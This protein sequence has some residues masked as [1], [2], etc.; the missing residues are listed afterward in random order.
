MLNGIRV[1]DLTRLYPGPYSTLFLSDYGAEVIKIEDKQVG[2]YLRDMSSDIQDMN[3]RFVALNRGKKSVSLNLKEK[4]DYNFF[5]ELIKTADILVESFRPGVMERLK[6]DYKTL[7]KINK[8]LIFCSITGFGQTGPYA[9]KAGHDLNYTSLSGLAKYQSDF[10]G[11]PIVPG[12]QIS[13]LAGGSMMAIS[14]ILLALYHRERTGKG[15][16]ID[17]SMLDGTLSLMISLFPDYFSGKEHKP[18]SERLTGGLACYNLYETKDNEWISVACLEKKFWD[19]FCRIMNREEWKSLHLETSDIQN[20]LKEEISSIF[21]QEDQ[22]FWIEMFSESDCC[23]T[24]VYA[25]EDVIKDPHI[26]ARQLIQEADVDGESFYYIRK[27]VYMSEDHHKPEMKAPKRGE[28]DHIFRQE[29][30]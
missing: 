29:E 15:Q 22:S 30:G 25:L 13:D 21:K 24:P 9:T 27:P 2:D 14:S 19:E 12:F 28:H 23:V 6:L 7:K 26:K 8:R 18:G 20:Q 3:A 10:S 1:V 11:R 17:V 4:E 16:H 5:L